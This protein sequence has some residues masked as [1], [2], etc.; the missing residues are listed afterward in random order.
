MVRSLKFAGLYGLVFL[1]LESLSILQVWHSFNAQKTSLMTGYTEKLEHSYE[2]TTDT[3]KLV[4]QTIYNEAIDRPEV[5]D[6]IRQ[7][8]TATPE[9]QE[10]L[11]T[12]LF[13]KLDVTYEKL[14]EQHLRQLHFHLPD[15]T[16][17]LRMHRPSKF[18]DPLFD[19]RY[20]VKI[21]NQQQRFVS[22]FEEGRIFNGFRYVFPLFYQD[23]SGKKQHIGSVETSIGFQAIRNEMAK[24]FSGCFEFM[25]RGDV[26]RS[27]VFTNEL[28]NYVESPLNSEFVIESEAM[29]NRSQPQTPTCHRIDRLNRQ[30]KPIIADRLDRGVPFAIALRLEAA[31][32]VATFFPV[33]NLQDRVVAYIVS[34][35]Q[36]FNLGDYRSNAFLVLSIAT[37]FNLILM[38]FIAYVN[39]SRTVLDRQNKTLQNEVNARTL[40]EQQAQ[41]KSE[42]LQDALDRLKLAQIKLIQTEK[43]T[44][45]NQLVAGVA[46]EINNPIGFIYGNVHHAREYAE[47]LDRAIQLYQQPNSSNNASLHAQLKDLELD[48][49]REDFPK[50]LDSMKSGA[51]RVESIVKSLRNFSR[52]DESEL[53]LVKI[54]DGIDS[55]LTLLHHRLKPS[56]KRG[57]IEMVK[58]FEDL[59]PL[60]CYAS[61]LNQAF[62]SILANAID[63]IDRHPP[64]KETPR[65]GMSAT[66]SKKTDMVDRILIEISNNGDTIPP[67]ILDRIFDP[68]FTTKPIGQGTGLGLSTAYFIV[69]ETHGG[70]L[71]CRSEPG[72]DTVFAIELPVKQIHKQ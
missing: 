24:L 47:I 54:R 58:T 55:T 59:P 27:K 34:Y 5:I 16:S 63:A 6:L 4:S 12:E 64:Q 43:M 17:F 13:Q 40:A 29:R 7:A 30:L 8:N 9:A 15:G 49:V 21:A 36:D 32:Y 37:G 22:G 46:H 50:L 57:E 33:K 44:S 1:L 51:M 52:L 11:R 62:M 42:A 53:K 70:Q 69:V 71:T 19:V 72:R 3:Y 48:F 60:E 65:I 56:E 45:L 20:S 61:L 31:D 25:L 68:F 66:L 26:V 2:I 23:D 38:T 10:A 14:K 35:E 67:E 39:R 41:Q 18:G 28:S